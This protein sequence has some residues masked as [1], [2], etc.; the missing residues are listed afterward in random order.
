LTILFLATRLDEVGGVQVHIRDLARWLAGQGHQVHVAAGE[1]A[2]AGR[3]AGAT[4]SAAP[5]PAPAVAPALE[6]AFDAAGVTVHLL[7]HLARAINPLKDLIALGEIRRLLK[8]LQPDLVSLHSSKAGWIGRQAA[9]RDWTVRG[10]RGLLP[11]VGRRRPP[12]IFTAHGWAFTGGV[13]KVKARL[14]RFL[15]RR[16]AHLADAVICVSD[17]D[18]SLAVDAGIAERTRVLTIHNG[19]PDLPAADTKPAALEAAPG[20]PVTITMVARF[21]YQKR[22]ELL[23]KALGTLSGAQAPAGPPGAPWRLQL[24]GSG[25]REPEIRS[26]AEELRLADRVEFPGA[27]DDVPELL[28]ASDLFVLTSR[29]EGLPRSIIEAM[30]AGLPVVASAVG[31]VGELV[32]DGRTGFLLDPDLEES[33]AA[34]ELAGV[35]R[36]LLG[37]ADLRHALGAAGRRRYEEHFTFERMAVETAGLYQE[38]LNER[39]KPHG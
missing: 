16:A 13:P 1:K 39:K 26:L 28:S 12:V 5:A 14:Y 15:E 37:S 36:R 8:E 19:M 17:H 2:A 27:R 20:L 11:G 10:P 6:E 23:L 3:P 7:P 25:E 29:W 18:R 31:G 4:A 33:S 21:G 30:R 35:L 22:Q 9:E 34:A 38:L 32:E 24:V